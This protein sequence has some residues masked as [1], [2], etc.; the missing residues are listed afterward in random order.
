MQVRRRSPILV[1]L[2]FLLSVNR[3]R[4]QTAPITIHETVVVT[5]TG[6]EEP[7]SQVGASISVLTTE[8]I[9][10]RHALTLIDL[11]RTMPGIAAVRTGGVGGLTA[12]WTRGGWSGCVALVVAIQSAGVAI[13][14][15]Q[16]SPA[17]AHREVVLTD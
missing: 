5:A 9:E 2:L 3:A 8:Q 13:A 15:T 7:V 10:Q 16:W 1:S 12:L 6:R 17:Q 11:L 4:A 14:F